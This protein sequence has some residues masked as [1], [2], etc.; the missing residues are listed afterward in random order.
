VIAAAQSEDLTIEAMCRM[1]AEE[2]LDDT[3]LGVLAD[4]IRRLLGEDISGW[5]VRIQGREQ[6]VPLTLFIVTPTALGEF[7]L[8]P[9]KRTARVLPLDRIAGYEEER[10]PLPSR[11]V[12]P[13]VH[14]LS[15]ITISIWMPPGALEAQGHAVTMEEDVRQYPPGFDPDY[16]LVDLL[17]R[18]ADRFSLA[19]AAA[20]GVR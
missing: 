3:D 6:L 12:A 18:F 11:P 15:G 8:A 2:T 4:Q 10:R 17:A 16:T 14:A 20:M 13:S 1:A 19:F 9:R 7:S 5:Y